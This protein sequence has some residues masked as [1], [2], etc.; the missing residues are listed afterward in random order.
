[1]SYILDALKKIEHEKN[2]KT[3]QDG[4]VSISGDL[5]HEQKQLPARVGIWNRLLIIAVAALVTFAGTWYLLKGN[6]QKPA[7]V[8]S[9]SAQQQ[10][11][12]AVAKQPA[13]Q[14]P[15]TSLSQPVVAV[16]Q[17][18]AAVVPKKNMVDEDDSPSMQRAIKPV[19][20]VKTEAAVS[21][22][23]QQAPLTTAAPAD[24]KLSGIAWQDDRHLRRAVINGYL[25]KEGAIVSGARIT[26]ILIDRVRFSSN[27]GL[28][29]VK[30]DAVLPA[31]VQK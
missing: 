26:D 28:F 5:F 12:V 16:P 7:A 8:V 19:P 10:P 11:P 15:V 13:P 22:P 23:R 14:Q 31:E 21:L 17:L 6:D 3:R 18:P 27:A 1:M 2:K 24:I 20:R 9:I 30:L 25:L 29:E 4:T